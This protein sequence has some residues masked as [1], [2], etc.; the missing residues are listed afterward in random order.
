MSKYR[1]GL[2]AAAGV[3][4]V[5]GKVAIDGT[6]TGIEIAELLGA[7]AIA[8]GVYRVPNELPPSA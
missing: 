7:L 8:F 5:I 2:I 1:K 4:A 3:A 6:L